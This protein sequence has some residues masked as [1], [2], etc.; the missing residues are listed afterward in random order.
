MEFAD[1]RYP[2]LVGPRDL[3]VDDH[4]E[5]K[6]AEHRIV[7]ISCSHPSPAG[8]LGQGVTSARSNLDHKLRFNSGNRRMYILQNSECAPRSRRGPR[9][10]PL[11]VQYRPWSGRGG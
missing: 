8:G 9:H 2:A 6:P 11:P 5:P 1:M 7:L 3:A 4:R 10:N